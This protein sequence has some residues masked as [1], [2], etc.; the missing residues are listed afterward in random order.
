MLTVSACVVLFYV[1]THAHTHT[2]RFPIIEP[3][4]DLS[5]IKKISLS[6]PV[7]LKIWMDHLAVPLMMGEDGAEVLSLVQK[8]YFGGLTDKNTA[9][10]CLRI[11]NTA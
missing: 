3:M 8:M 11:I 2:H 10:I 9:K 7:V 4:K 6:Q 1:H 5:D